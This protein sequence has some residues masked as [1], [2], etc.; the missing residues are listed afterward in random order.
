M[1]L[2]VV[3][4]GENYGPYD[5][6]HFSI[7]DSHESAAKEIFREAEQNDDMSADF[8]QAIMEYGSYA[9]PHSSAIWYSLYE[10]EALA[11]HTWSVFCMHWVV[12]F[13]CA[14]YGRE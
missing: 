9:G 2:Y 4:T 11:D 1:K 6:Q 12:L 3:H 5:E 14:L 13:S 7:H 10:I 8:E